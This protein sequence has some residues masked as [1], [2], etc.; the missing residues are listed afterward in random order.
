MEQIQEYDETSTGVWRIEYRLPGTL[1]V[2]PSDERQAS[3]MIRLRTPGGEEA[4]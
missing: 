2:E 1:H 3:L 4:Q